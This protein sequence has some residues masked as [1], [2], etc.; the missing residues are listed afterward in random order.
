MFAGTFLLP[1][2][3]CAICCTSWKP[4]CSTEDE[5]EPAQDSNVYTI[6][7]AS[8]ASQIQTSDIGVEL[9]GCQASDNT[10]GNLTGVKTLKHYDHF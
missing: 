4:C 9:A 3:I 8:H 2:I 7:R 1:A 5:T 6:Q 10:L